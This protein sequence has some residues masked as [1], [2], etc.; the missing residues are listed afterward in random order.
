MESDFLIM[1][2]Q[3]ALNYLSMTNLGSNKDLE[4]LFNMVM[5]CIMRLWIFNQHQTSKTIHALNNDTYYGSL[6]GIGLCGVLLSVQSFRAVLIVK[7]VVHSTHECTFKKCKLLKSEG[8]RGCI[9]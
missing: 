2:V 7:V 4:L 9:V 5:V 6:G 8:A 1:T 3:M